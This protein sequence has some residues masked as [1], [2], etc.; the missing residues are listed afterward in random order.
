MTA[1]FFIC[2]Y[3]EITPKEFFDTDITAPTKARELMEAVRGLNVE[4]MDS[5]ISIAKNLKR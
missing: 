1:F 5:L 3:L 2:D 4:Q